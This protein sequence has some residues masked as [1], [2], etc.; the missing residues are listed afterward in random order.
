MPGS[1]S[2]IYMCQKV[3]NKPLEKLV[4]FQGS[5]GLGYTEMATSKKELS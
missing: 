4:D 1:F 5:E 2:K 3:R